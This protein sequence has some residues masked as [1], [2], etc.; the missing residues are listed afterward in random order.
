MKTKNKYVQISVIYTRSVTNTPIKICQVFSM[1]E[2][3]NLKTSKKKIVFLANS[4]SKKKRRK[5]NKEK[6]NLGRRAIFDYRHDILVSVLTPYWDY[7][8]ILIKLV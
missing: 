3:D 6:N 4:H 7:N 5:K 8:M 2:F 1:Y